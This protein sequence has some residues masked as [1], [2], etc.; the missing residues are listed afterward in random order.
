MRSQIA[1]SL[2]HPRWSPRAGPSIPA[3]GVIS[4]IESACFP[5]TL[6][7]GG[8]TLS[9]GCSRNAQSF[10]AYRRAKDILD[11]HRD[12]LEALANALLE[13]ETL[14]GTQVLEIVKTGKLTPPPPTPKVEPPIGAIAATPLSDVPK[15][16]PPK[17][18]P[19]FGAPAPAAA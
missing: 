4:T 14:D 10:E 7:T 13:Y 2:T 3:N 18:E 8:S 15:T 11:T 5:Q 12:K 19:G 16:S 1:P 9:L 17:L 6:L